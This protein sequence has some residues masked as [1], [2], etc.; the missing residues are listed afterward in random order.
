MVKK[1]KN[2][3]TYPNISSLSSEIGTMIED[4]TS[5]VKLVAEQTSRIPHIEKKVNKIEEDMKI[6]KM[7]MELV[8][9]GFKKKVDVDEFAALEHRVALLESRR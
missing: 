1:I 5:Q 2:T 3:K 6:I 8:K 4:F 9:Y 7:D